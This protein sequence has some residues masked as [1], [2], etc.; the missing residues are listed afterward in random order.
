MKSVIAPEHDN[1]VVF[2]RRSVERIEQAA[3]LMIHIADAGKVAAHKFCPLPVVGNPIVPALPAMTVRVLEIIGPML[4][5]FHFIKR[6]QIEP[7]LRHF[8]RDVGS[9][10]SNSKK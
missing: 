1:R 9:K 2:H 5:Q 8:P 6:I 4:G 7:S 10:Q 3:K